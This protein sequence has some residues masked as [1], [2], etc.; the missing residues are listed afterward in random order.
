MTWVYRSV[1]GAPPGG[2]PKAPWKGWWEVGYYA[3]PEGEEYGNK[4]R[5]HVVEVL[6]NK[7]DARRAVHYLNGGQ[8]L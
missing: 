7:G 8:L 5:F 6:D 1:T 2:D 4:S 3:V